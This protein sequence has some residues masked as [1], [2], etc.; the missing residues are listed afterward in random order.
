MGDT[1]ATSWGVRAKAREIWDVLT[2]TWS[3]FSEDN[4]ELLGAALAF[5]TLLSLAPL[6]L[7]AVAVAGV[8]LGADAARGEVTRLLQQAVGRSAATTINGW[9]DE[10]ARSGGAASLVGIGLSLLGASRMFGQLRVALNQI[11][12]VD[13]Y[14]SQGFR[15]T[16]EDYVKRRLLAFGMVLGAGVVLL[17][18]FVARTMLAA[19]GAKIFAHS[20]LLGQVVGW[21]Q[22]GLSLVVVAAIT[23]MIFKFVPDTKMG[24][25]AAWA[26]GAVTSILF[27]LGNVLVGMYLGRATLA[28]TY[29]AAGSLVIV[30]VWFAFSAQ[31]LLFGA[32][33]TQVILVKYGLGLDQDEEREA[34]RLRD[35]ARKKADDAARAHVKRG[36]KAHLPT[37]GSHVHA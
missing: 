28:A 27:N 37:R 24:W 25:R 8:F 6:L 30:L 15:D 22:I 33:L 29:G 19:V 18:T 9:V 20:P 26:G 1:G 32:E 36:R 12:D 31:V 7:I 14:M 16:V 17:A 4:G 10:A 3:G 21:A 35:E 2:Q 5:Y 23:A 11:F 13:V 34:W